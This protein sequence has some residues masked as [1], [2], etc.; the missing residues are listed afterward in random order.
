MRLHCIECGEVV[1][2]EI[3]DEIVV[4]IRGVIICPECVEGW[5]DE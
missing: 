1:S 5:E 2:N 3:P 4:I